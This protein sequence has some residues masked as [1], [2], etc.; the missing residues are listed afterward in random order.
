[1]DAS[2]WLK[3]RLLLLSWAIALGIGALVMVQLL[4]S[5]TATWQ[6]AQ[7][8]NTNLLFTVSHVV[9]RTLETADGALLHAVEVLERAAIESGGGA[10]GHFR[11]LDVELLFAA[12][13]SNG[14]GVQLV[15]DDQGR[16]LFASRESPV[17]GRVFRDRAYFKVHEERSDKGFFMGAPFI[18]SFDGQPSVAMSRRWNLPDGSFGGIVV[19]TLKLSM[20]HSLFS[21]FELGP[22]SGINVFLTDGSVVTRFPYTN[23]HI[24]ASLSGTANFER[25]IRD[26]QGSFTSTAFIDQVDRLYVFRTLDRFPVIV[27]VAQATHA[28]QGV[29]QR[30]AIW[31]GGAT[32]ILMCAGVFL[33]VFAEREL[34]AH[35]QT[36]QRLRQAEHELRTII[37]SLPVMVAYWDD[38]FINRMANN[39]HEHWLGLSPE[40]MK[41]RHIDELD[42]PLI[43]YIR[44]YLDATLA[45][46]LQTFES[47]L[48]DKMG[49][50]R[51]AITTFIPD[52]E[53]GKV[54][55][56]F[57]MV[58]DISERKS[59]ETAL[60]EEKERFQVIL[61]S[62]KDGVI[63]TD[64]QGRILYLN[65]AAAAL[66]GWQQDEACG[67]PVEAVMRVEV[68]DGSEDVACPL[69]VSLDTRKAFKTKVEHILVSRR[70][71]RVHIENSA[72]P[73]LD[74]QGELRGAVVIFH[75]VGQVRAMANRM[76]HLAQ[77]DAL[78]GLPNRRRLDLVGASALSRASEE[79]RYLAVLYLD[80]DGFK[81][82]NDEYGH[83]VGDQLLVA[84][85]H[86]LSARLRS[87][88][89]MYRQGG[90]EFVVLMGQLAAPEDA[91]RLAAR[92]IES[93]RAPVGISGKELL[94][95]VSIGIGIYPDDA[96]ELAELLQRADR[97]M[98]AAKKAGRNCYARANGSEPVHC[99]TVDSAARVQ[100]ADQK[101]QSAIR[102]SH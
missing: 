37:D 77:H 65:P 32:L 86:R 49:V 88:D 14:Y 102:F 42:E 59:V 81:R 64:P 62:I 74:E 83:A 90:D 4:E 96:I 84:V 79:G 8:A 54:Q 68:P 47:I 55:G 98:Y 5:R 33:A 87:A 73:I 40:Q 52:W 10:A 56:F 16:I 28:I 25:F 45:G 93:C 39:A 72:A 22:D 76:I 63:T 89:V 57:V 67:K 19:Q 50:P 38:R 58:T 70:G 91:E 31:L 7:A 75:E 100:N 15:L 82:V 17:G 20:L 43:Q 29:W 85:T 69:Q 6:R 94:V 60:F 46:E 2:R 78:T 21:S 1:M 97:A 27:N 12:V 101:P 30:N 35:R 99:D 41:G 44:P 80:L 26:G 3:S 53:G 92:L 13:A 95:T 34:R 23:E 51:H 61:E 24:G 36:A 11:D 9:E 71:R 66:T 18:S 48:P